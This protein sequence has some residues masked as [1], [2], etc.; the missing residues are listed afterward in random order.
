MWSG[1]IYRWG[2]KLPGSTTKE[3]TRRDLPPGSSKSILCGSP[4]QARRATPMTNDTRKTTRKRKNRIFA[5]PAE[6]TEIPP[7]P[8]I[9]ATIAIRK[10]TRA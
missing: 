6:A 9:A 7:N 8:K 10:N 4:R 1:T 3:K 2:R 5:I